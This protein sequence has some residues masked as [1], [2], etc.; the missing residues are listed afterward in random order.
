[1]KSQARTSNPKIPSPRAVHITYIFLLKYTLYLKIPKAL[2]NSANYALHLQDSLESW[3]CGDRTA[4]SK[5]RMWFES[6]MKDSVE[7]FLK[8]GPIADG[9]DEEGDARKD[10]VH[11][12]QFNPD[13]NSVCTVLRSMVDVLASAPFRGPESTTFFNATSLFAE[14]MQGCA[15]ACVPLS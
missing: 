5:R 12:L 14:I 7:G 13:N 4:P 10:M 15:G 11:L 3:L 8:S 6:N 1:M 2:F 9:T